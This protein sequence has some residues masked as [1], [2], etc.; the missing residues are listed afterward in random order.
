[1]DAET[2]LLSDFSCVPFAQRLLESDWLADSGNGE[3]RWRDNKGIFGLGER[4]DNA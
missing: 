2:T 4:G 1:M 3:R